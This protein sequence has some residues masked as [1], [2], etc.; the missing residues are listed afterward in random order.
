MYMPLMR[1]WEHHLEILLKTDESYSILLFGTKDLYITRLPESSLPL[2]AEL[3][4]LTGQFLY[5]QAQMPTLH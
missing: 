4:C 1:E 2:V 3:T 5:F